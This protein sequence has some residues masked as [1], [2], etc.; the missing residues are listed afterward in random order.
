MPTYN[1]FTSFSVIRDI[2]EV[3][4]TSMS[5]FFTEEIKANADKEKINKTV[6][7][8][9]ITCLGPIQHRGRAKIRPKAWDLR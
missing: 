4:S 1:R 7:I 9:V 2:S 3:R 6:L 5:I 8:A